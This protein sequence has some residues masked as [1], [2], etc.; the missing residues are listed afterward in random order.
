M[1]SDLD[2]RDVDAAVDDHVL[3]ADSENNSDSVLPLAKSLRLANYDWQR[4]VK[5]LVG[6]AAHIS[7][8]QSSWT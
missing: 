1:L 5:K 4:S 8:F 6:G 2:A 3:M 7:T